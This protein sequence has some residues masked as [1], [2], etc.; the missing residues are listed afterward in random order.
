MNQKWGVI[1]AALVIA[2]LMYVI[3][4]YSPS[5]T[6]PVPATFDPLNAA[7]IINGQAVTLVNGLSQAPAAPGSASMVTTRIFGTPTLGDLDGDGVPDAAFL[8]TQDGGGSGTFFYVAAALNENGLTVGTN[9]FFV[10]DRIAP[11]NV[12][13][14]NGTITV[15]YADRKPGEPMTVQPSI[16]ISRYFTVQGNNLAEIK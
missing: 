6:S 16:G 15:N 5:T 12:L 7:Y 1:V 11:Q 2:V 3:S 14:S 13:I 4:V 9:A 10:G 8:I